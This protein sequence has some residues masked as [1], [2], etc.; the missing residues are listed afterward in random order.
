MFFNSIRDDLLLTI[1]KACANTIA[2]NLTSAFN[3]FHLIS[4]IVRQSFHLCSCES[5]KKTEQNS[6]I[7]MGS[8]VYIIITESMCNIEAGII[9]APGFMYSFV[10]HIQEQWM[11]FICRL[12]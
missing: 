4:R 12:G 7:H 3:P 10:I 8:P 2:I 6:V 5:C 9:V 1:C 11:N